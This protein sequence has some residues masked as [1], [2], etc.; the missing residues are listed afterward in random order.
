MFVIDTV[1]D[2]FCDDWFVRKTDAGI[3]RK[4]KTR[5]TDWRNNFPAFTICFCAIYC[6]RGKQRPDYTN[7]N[8]INITQPEW[9]LRCIVI[10]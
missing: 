8:P 5:Q 3:D 4:P 10:Y 6:E 9:N 7:K 1:I 2:N